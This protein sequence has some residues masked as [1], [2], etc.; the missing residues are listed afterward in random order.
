MEVKMERLKEMQIEVLIEK[1]IDKDRAKEI[2]NFIS[3]IK[4][5]YG[6]CYYPKGNICD[7]KKDK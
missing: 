5:V 7:C 3:Q 4:G 6:V 1:G 2:R